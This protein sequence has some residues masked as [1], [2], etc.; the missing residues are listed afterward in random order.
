MH[1]CVCTWLGEL[2]RCRAVALSLRRFVLRPDI[3]LSSTPL[4]N[5]RVRTSPIRPK[6]GGW[7]GRQKILFSRC[8]KVLPRFSRLCRKQTLVSRRPLVPSPYACRLSSLPVT[9]ETRLSKMNGCAQHFRQTLLSDGSR[10]CHLCLERR[11]H[12]LRIFAPPTSCRH[13]F[14]QKLAL[15]FAVH[16]AAGADGGVEGSNL[17]SAGRTKQ[18]AHR[19]EMYGN[20]IATTEEDIKTVGSR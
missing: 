5:C 11:G 16:S 14:P 7:D 13:R 20:K 18:A 15:V 19:D 6:H 3:L 12:V 17:V 1:E 2:C 8:C 9:H 10:R 4:S